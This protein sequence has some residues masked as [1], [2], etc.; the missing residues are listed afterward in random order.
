M[1]RA[2]IVL[3]GGRSRR[4]GRPKALLPW[5][6]RRLV[7]HVVASLAPAVDEVLI[8]TSR[9]IPLTGLAAGARIVVEQDPARGPLAALRDGLAAA[10]P[11]LAFVTS[12]DAPCLT[13]A[14]VETVLA[15]AAAAGGAVAPVADGFV[16]VLSAAYPG[17]ALH[18][19]AAL[20]AAGGSSPLALL[21]RIGFVPFES[22]LPAFAIAPWTGFNDPDAYLELAR[23]CDREAAA[24]VEWWSD[25]R[26]KARAPVPIGRLDEVLRAVERAAVGL[27]LADGSAPSRVLL[28]G[29]HCTLPAD[30]GLP[31]GPGDRLVVESD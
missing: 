30:A 2:G 21:E 26:L 18:A 5:F 4:M 25:G 16:Q 1:K 17:S 10:R 19:A 27:A 20:L 22:S 14:H 12:T 11:D 31:V 13:A 28:D 15:R 7:E 9:E 23:R 8:V 3:A 24:E 29:R 6:G